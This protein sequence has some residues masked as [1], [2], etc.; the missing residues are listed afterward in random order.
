MTR[1]GIISDT[2]SWW[3]ERFAYYFSTCDIILHA[4]D[5]GSP[6]VI[7]RL[8]T[9]APVKG[10][11]GNIDGPEIR[12]RF[13]LVANFYIESLH[14]V[15]THIGGY[16]GKYELGIKQTLLREKEN[17]CPVDLFISGHSHILKVIP[18]K[19][20]GLLH[21]NPGAAGIQGWQTVRTLVTLDIDGAKM[22]NLQVIELAHL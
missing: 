10:V 13:P 20:L 17:G 14:V 19:N 6:L 18:D 11:Y 4:G 5:V 21:I 1:V 9:I 2:H 7:D 12:E 16:P 22:Q 3:D 15:I 8:E